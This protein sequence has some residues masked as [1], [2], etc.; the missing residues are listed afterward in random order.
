V[1]RTAD[2]G[3][4]DAGS[5]G[6]SNLTILAFL[7][8]IAALVHQVAKLTLVSS[9][10]AALV[11]SSSVLLL[12]R[13]FCAP[14]LLLF[15]ASQLWMLGGQDPPAVDNHWLLVGC[16]NVGL[17]C[18]VASAARRDGVLP[19]RVDQLEAFAFPLVRGC[20]LAVYAF[21]AFHKLNSGFL[22][23]RA[24]CATELY[25]VL[26]RR[27]PLP[28]G[29]WV[30]AVAIYGSLL[31]EIAIPA[32][33][34]SRRLRA[35]GILY[36]LLFHY[37]LGLAGFFNFSFTMVAL[38]AAFLPSGFGRAFAHL[39][40][41]RARG[42]RPT[43]WAA[44]LLG[45]W[46]LVFLAIAGTLARRGRA[47]DP[48]RLVHAGGYALWILYGAPIAAGVSVVA[49]SSA[50]GVCREV[51]RITPQ[52]PWHAV[53]FGLILLNGF[54]PYLGLKTEAAFSMY[55]NLRTEGPHWN[56]LLLPARLQLGPYQDDLVSIHAST[57]DVLRQSHER[58]EELVGVEFG[59]LVGRLCRH[60]GAP[61][62]VDYTRNGS[63]HLVTDACEAASRAR[64]SPWAH[65][66]LV[67]RPV[68]AACRH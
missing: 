22:D 19:W 37:V 55:S 24:S 34:V 56:H 51:I 67:F 2:P 58:G 54:S 11:S 27:F 49:A 26:A 7:L 68:T 10:A 65:R 6:W 30:D 14:A 21:S 40:A 28:A 63:R 57:E 38:Y 29:G 36:G 53:T 64:P 9:I 52:R 42:R 8:A 16:V 33:L 66:F 3:T 50:G 23:P 31:S 47:L 32:F 4:F 5:D 60:P 61:V 41:S 20:L 43:S 62:A 12:V 46:L 44:L 39:W 18:T 15:A 35:V 48:P 1:P 45:A 13:P 17:L 59:R 25:Q